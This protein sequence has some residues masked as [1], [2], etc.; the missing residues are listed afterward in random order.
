ML[1]LVPCGDMAF[2]S[3]L[4]ASLPGPAK[5]LRRLT[6]AASS[7]RSPLEIWQANQC[8]LDLIKGQRPARRSVV[9]RP[10]TRFVKKHTRKRTGKGAESRREGAEGARKYSGNGPPDGP[11]ARGEAGLFFGKLG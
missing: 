11:L 9:R 7:R 2:S 5:H 8:W 3:Q 6:K 4:A 1:S 10:V